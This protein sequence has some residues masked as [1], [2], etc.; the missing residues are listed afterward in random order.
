MKQ[1]CRSPTAYRV[2]RLSLF[3]L[4]CHLP[5]RTQLVKGAKST[6]PA[7]DKLGLAGITLSA[8]ISNLSNIRKKRGKNIWN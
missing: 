6:T 1:K 8:R 5:A 4:V 7:L 3:W 2:G